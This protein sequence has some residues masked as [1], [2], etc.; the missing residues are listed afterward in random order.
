M[1]YKVGD[2]VVIVKA[3]GHTI[4]RAKIPLKDPHPEHI[5]KLGS[6]TTIDSDDNMPHIRLDDGT[7]LLGCECW[8]DYAKD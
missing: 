8:W 4:G 6:I 3:E 5:G 2:R 1:D 7:V